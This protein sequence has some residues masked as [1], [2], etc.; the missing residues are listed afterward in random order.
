ME[1]HRKILYKEWHS[2][3]STQIQQVGAGQSKRRVA[4][5]L[6]RSSF[7]SNIL[8]NEQLMSFQTGILPHGTHIFPS[9]TKFLSFLYR[10]I[11][12]PHLPLCS[13]PPYTSPSALATPSYT[14]PTEVTKDFHM[15]KSKRCW[16][17]LSF[18]DLS[19]A[20]DNIEYC[21]FLGALSFVCITPFLLATLF[22]HSLN[23][24]YCSRF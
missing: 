12:A 22:C 21:L 13:Q 23:C 4:D 3:S 8:I 14:P 24:R 19:A 20:S 9:S 15:A 1:R 18:L 10:L 17:V 11:L 6:E 5:H 7:F 2:Q 16:S